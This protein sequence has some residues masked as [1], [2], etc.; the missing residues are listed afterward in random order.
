MGRR[1]QGCRSRA[2]PISP[3]AARRRGKTRTTSEDAR[4][5]AGRRGGR[6]GFSEGGAQ[7]SLQRAGFTAIAIRWF[8]QRDQGFTGPGRDTGQSEHPEHPYHPRTA[9]DI[10]HP[11]PGWLT[12]IKFK[13]NNT[14]IGL[15]QLRNDREKA[16]LRAVP[17][18]FV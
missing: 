17:G 6:K 11:G 2:R 8:P 9:N 15:E 1:F 5:R 4:P 7:D 18:A 12:T 16:R 13:S 10:T 14:W 3:K